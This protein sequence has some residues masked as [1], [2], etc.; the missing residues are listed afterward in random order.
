MGHLKISCVF[1][2][3]KTIGYHSFSQF[4]W[5]VH[6]LVIWLKRNLTV[7]YFSRVLNCNWNGRKCVSEFLGM[8]FNLCCFAIHCKISAEQTWRQHFIGQEL[9]TLTSQISSNQ[10]KWAG[11]GVVTQCH[12]IKRK[13]DFFI[14]FFF[15]LQ[16][17]LSFWFKIFDNI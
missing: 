8:H 12:G 3:F 5:K 10:V 11:G 4:T 17:I 1:Y 16:S 7:I 6:F 9:I 15:L 2:I 14:Y 13:S